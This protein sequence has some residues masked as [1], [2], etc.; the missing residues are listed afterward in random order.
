VGIA[1]QKR[2]KYET[3]VPMYAES[4][5]I[6]RRIAY[7]EG[8]QKR[9]RSTGNTLGEILRSARSAKRLTLRAVAD[10]AHISH[11]FVADLELG[12]R[13]ASDDVLE[14]ISA[15]VGADLDEVMR[16]AARIRIAALKAKLEQ[17]EAAS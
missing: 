3:S 5:D 11:G 17:L 8:M 14:R 9:K 2:A 12:R 4:V 7:I 1:Y 16:A 13:N 10:A 15:A 6:R